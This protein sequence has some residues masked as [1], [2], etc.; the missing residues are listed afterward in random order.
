MVTLRWEFHKNA[1]I[2]D[3]NYENAPGQI[4][5]LQKCLTSLSPTQPSSL[6]IINPVIN[7]S[8]PHI[9]ITSLSLNY[10]LT[11]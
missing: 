7:P 4:K 3:R 5:T 1:L 2:S 8:D 11:H 9:E 6:S 10:Y